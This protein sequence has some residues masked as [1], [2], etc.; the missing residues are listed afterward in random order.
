[1]GELHLE[2]NCQPDAARIPRRG[3]RRQA[4]SRIHRDDYAAG[5]GR[6]RFVRQTGGRGQYGHAWLELEPLPRGSGFEFVNKIV[7]GAIPREYI[8]AVED[9][10]REALESG[11][12]QGFRLV[13]LRATLYDGSYHDVDSSEIAFRIAGSMALRAAV[14]DA[15][16]LMLEPI[17][18]VE[19]VVP[20]SSLGDI[21]GDLSAR[22]GRVRRLGSRRGHARCQG[23]GSSGHD[24]W[25][26]EYAT[27]ADAGT[28]HVL[29]GVCALRTSA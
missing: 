12:P 8:S 20:E 13:D 9:G 15:A 7:G 22:R 4:A 5:Q 21:I 18:H 14:R 26:R 1:M 23:Y 2:V 29:H 25:V 16:P 11:G 27:L 17:M 19:V 24:V 6:G 3:Q 10:V 28:W